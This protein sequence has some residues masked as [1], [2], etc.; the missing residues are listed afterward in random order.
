MNS[1]IRRRMGRIEATLAIASL[2]AAIA[3]CGSSDSQDEPAVGTGG[4]G[5]GT[6]GSSGAAGGSGKGGSAGAAG[7]AGKGGGGGGGA[8]GAAGTGGAGGSG[9]DSDGDCS[10]ATPVCDVA[11]GK[12]V[13]CL[14]SGKPCPA[15]E[16][17]DAANTCVAGCAK[18]EDC[19]NGGGN[20]LVCDTTT[21]KCVGCATDENCPLGSLCQQGTCVAG[22]TDQHACPT[23]S[24]CCTGQCFD[25]ATDA[26]H[27]GGCTACPEPAEAHAQAICNNSVCGFGTCEA[28]FGDCNNDSTDGCESDLG[29]ETACPCVPGAK[30]NCYEGLPGTLGNG[31]CAEGTKTCNA[32]GK[33][34]GPCEGQ[35]LPQ[36]ETCNNA[37]DDDCNGKV[38]DSGA[39]CVCVP[40]QAVA[41]YD[42]PFDTRN[43]GQCKDGT[44]TCD[45]LGQSFGPCTGQTLPGTEDCA[46]PGDENCDG[47]VNESSA[48][49]V[50]TAGATTACYG[51]PVGT[52]DVGPCVGGTQTCNADGKGWGPCVGEVIPQTETCFNDIDDD[53]NGLVNEGGP[54]CI[55]APNS[56]DACYDGEPSTIGV[57]LCVGGTKSCN[58]LGT[59]WS[60]CVGQV[61]PQPETCLT[62]E[63]DNCN[64]QT[65]ESG[66]GC[67]CAPGS[68]ASCYSGPAG[69][70]GVGSCVAGTKQC[71]SMGT[72]W[73]ACVGEVLPAQESCLTPW[74]DNCNGQTNE[75]GIGCVCTPG[76]TQSCYTG[77]AGTSGKGTCHAG[78]STCD[79]SGLSWGPCVGEVVPQFDSCATTADED[80]TGSNVVCTASQDC[81]QNS[82]VC[83]VPCDPLVLGKSYM[84]C[85]YYPTVTSNHWLSPR[86]APG[87]AGFHFAVAISN[88]RSVAVNYTITR[89]TTAIA[90]GSVAANSVQIVQL[91]WVEQLANAAASLVSTNAAGSGAYRL[92]TDRPVTV[93]QYNP[94]E[95]TNGGYFSYTNDASL[96][97]PVNAW[98]GNYMVASYGHWVYNG[99]SV[100]GLYAVTA[101]QDGTSVT[102]GPSATGKI[103]QGGGGVSSTGTGTITLN[104]GDV[105]QVMTRA[106][107]G[108]PDVSDLTGT[109]IT[110]S[111]PVQLIGG[112]DCTDVPYNITACDHIEEAIFPLETLSKTY[113]VTTP[114]IANNT[115]K[116][117]IVRV[118]ATASNTTLSYNPA[119]AGFPT[120]IAAAGGYVDLP[121]SQATY[122][123]TANNKIL[124]A[125]YMQGQDAG[126][127]I[128]DPA[129]SLAVAVEQYRDN[130]LFHAPV[131]YS[132][133]FVNITS[134]TG[135]TVLLDG[136][137]V[138]AASF[139][140]I[141]ATGYQ[142]ARVPLSNLGNGNHSITSGSK[143]GI[144]VYGYGSYTSYWYPG[145]L[146]LVD[147]QM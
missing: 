8:S 39:D 5:G 59:Q 21:H 128:G 35:V 146:D 65:N 119:Q 52:K 98:T 123:I 34:Y 12:C 58:S 144:S 83:Q 88:T 7:Q 137:A 117:H 16:Y 19:D 87:A 38:N 62:A 138:P 92:V 99:F 110:A 3:G 86:S 102:L 105:L 68:T 93:Y 14:P 101:S 64:G 129:M 63:D 118:I 141:G 77:P 67:V 76:A 13:G 142:A 70:A 20:P 60:S 9:C 41:C 6:A 43:I 120:T 82:G 75:G 103:V 45:A 127:G 28:G 17:C 126:G 47:N 109:T 44:M 91:P 108:S 131:S 135:A 84:G 50:C 27:C 122:V 94:L 114:W 10:G 104:K 107:G 134:P 97:E 11:S 42:G 80:C 116:N 140:A 29:G 90:I 51:G 133:N 55:C 130:Y 33:G 147:L 71:N 66:T 36:T 79:G 136:V 139:T 85:E 112:H 30:A 72:D 74:D 32:D 111:K 96:L 2:L 46:L 57:G 31:P 73:G 37:I 115:L 18:D 4:A 89:G 106:G 95:Y 25:T 113:I 145:G 1:W 61:V 81:N 121:A 48:G 23:G 49:C 54:G 125:Q 78:T 143:V 15:G 26:E 56:V 100:P 132:T 24:A 40:N 53:C 22:C 124:V 69:T